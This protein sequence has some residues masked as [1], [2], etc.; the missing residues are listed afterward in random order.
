MEIVK[1]NTV[2]EAVITKQN[3]YDFYNISSLN[4]TLSIIR[5]LVK[6]DLFPTNEI[7]IIQKIIVSNHNLNTSSI[8]PLLTWYNS[9]FEGYIVKEKEVKNYE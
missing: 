8:Y 5:S 4:L 3:P 6:N 1:E 9:L 2:Q 7:E